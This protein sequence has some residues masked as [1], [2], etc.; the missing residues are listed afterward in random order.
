MPI[1][2]H[3][4]QH[5][6][7][8]TEFKKTRIPHQRAEFKDLSNTLQGYCLKMEKFMSFCLCQINFKTAEPTGEVLR[9]L[10][11][12]IANTKE[13]WRKFRLTNVNVN[14]NKNLTFSRKCN[15]LFTKWK[16]SIYMERKW[17]WKY[18]EIRENFE[19]MNEFR[20]TKISME[21][22]GCLKNFHTRDLLLMK[23]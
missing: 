19:K 17:G 5:T 13:K 14:E 15:L 6:T 21:T 1:D 2:L 3:S 16:I 4:L 22:Y 11:K 20:S 18:I 23:A 10:Q 12:V 7:Q 9:C 8:Y